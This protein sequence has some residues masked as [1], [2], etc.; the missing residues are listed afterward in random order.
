MVCLDGTESLNRLVSMVFRPFA[1]KEFAISEGY[2]KGS[3]SVQTTKPVQEPKLGSSLGVFR[4]AN[5][6]ENP[7][8]N[9]VVPVLVQMMAGKAYKHW[10]EPFLIKER[11]AVS[12][13]ISAA[14]SLLDPP[15]K[16]GRG[17]LFSYPRTKIL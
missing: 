2:Y 12:A 7:N 17:R 1:T 5:S 9:Q 13:L 16:P 15:F 4:L 8:F 6:N 10:V 14:G 11:L 3:A